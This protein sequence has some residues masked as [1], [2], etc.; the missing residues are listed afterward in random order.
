MEESSVSVL[1]LFAH[2]TYERSRVNRHLVEAIADLSEVEIR[3]LYELYPE[4]DVDVDSEQEA[5]LRH[6]TVVFHHP[7]YWYSVPPLLK[8]WIDLVLEHGWAYG[9]KGNRLRGK[10]AFHVFTA[11]GG[12]AAYRQDGYNRFPIRAL[13]LAFEQ[14]AYLC[15]MRYLP[16]FVVHATHGMS[17]ETARGHAADYARLLTAFVRNQVDLER[18]ATMPRLNQDLDSVINGSMIEVAQ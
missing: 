10:T 11:G 1:V 16:P 12:E 2:P 9:A 3:D 4:F 14:T 15:G 7:L 8:Q 18:A 5:L 13:T 17:P 6:E